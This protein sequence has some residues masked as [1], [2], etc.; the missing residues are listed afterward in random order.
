MFYFVITTAQILF[1]SI[2]SQDSSSSSKMGFIWRL[3]AQHPAA[4][5]KPLMCTIEKHTSTLEPFL[6]RIP[7][8]D[9]VKVG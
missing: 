9:I 1:D 3:S 6:E 2:S 7:V 8:N 4:P 5:Y